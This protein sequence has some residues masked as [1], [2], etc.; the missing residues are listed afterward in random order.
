MGTIWDDFSDG[1]EAGWDVASEVLSGDT[2]PADAP[3][4][5]ADRYESRRNERE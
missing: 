5:V 1:F 3:G 2:D 4:E